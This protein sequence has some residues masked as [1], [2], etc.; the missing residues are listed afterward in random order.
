VGDLRVGGVVAI[1]GHQ[2]LVQLGQPVK[3]HARVQVV[4]QVVV[5][6]LAWKQGPLDQAGEGGL[7]AFESSRAVADRGVLADASDQ[8]NDLHPVFWCSS[9]SFLT[10]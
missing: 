7:G 3:G 10:C 6:P 4:L 9:M 2:V 5:D 1:C 8:E